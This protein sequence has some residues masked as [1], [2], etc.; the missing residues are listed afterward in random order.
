MGRPTFQCCEL[1]CAALVVMYR[2]CSLIT[3][4]LE[5]AYCKNDGGDERCVTEM[6][7]HIKTHEE[8]K[9]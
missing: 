9:S 1:G 2:Q 4:Q 6:V 8:K 5:M 3:C 7:A